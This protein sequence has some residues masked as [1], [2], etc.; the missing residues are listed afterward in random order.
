MEKSKRTFWPTQYCNNIYALHLPN[1]CGVPDVGPG[2]YVTKLW[3]SRSLH[4]S[5]GWERHEKNTQTNM[6]VVK[7]EETG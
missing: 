4:S 1:D 5:G 3:L 2:E 6:Q 7:T